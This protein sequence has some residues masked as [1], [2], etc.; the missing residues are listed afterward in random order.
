[1]KTWLI[2]GVSSGFGR[3]MTERLLVEG[4]RVAGTVRNPETV[5]DLKA[6]YGDQ[7]W[8]ARLD[9]TDGAA[10]RQVV[11]RA[12]AELGRIDVVV[13]NAGYGLF[14]AA[15]EL[16]DEQV[17]HHIDTNLVGSI[18][19]AR[20][21]LPHLRAQGGGRIVQI[22]TYG[23]Q[24]THPGATLY[25]ASKW[26]IE[27][28]MESLAQEVAPFGIGVTIV[29][30]GGARTGFRSTGAR[31]AAPLAAYDGTPAAMVRGIKSAPLSPGDP[32]K[33]AEEIIAA[34]Q[35]PGPLRLVLGSDA[36]TFVRDALAARLA[37][38]ET[39]KESAAATDV[40]AA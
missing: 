34:A 31:L 25:H 33:M 40:P 22:S 29:E 17:R 6:T 18:Q 4:S 19:V 37:E 2:T 20:A 13:N 23:G 21:A 5:A 39:Q 12:F 16:T 36:Y 1:V 3:L 28:F 35:R 26:G 32:A 9:V 11:D 7:L 30:P 14:G 38:I 10:V 8:T 24:A 15:E 27:G